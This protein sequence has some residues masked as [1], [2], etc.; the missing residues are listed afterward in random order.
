MIAKSINL[1]ECGVFNCIS[2]GTLSTLSASRVGLGLNQLLFLIRL[3]ECNVKTNLS[4]AAYLVPKRTRIIACQNI[5]TFEFK[6]SD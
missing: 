1:G 5:F 6:I 2:D 4:A 3:L